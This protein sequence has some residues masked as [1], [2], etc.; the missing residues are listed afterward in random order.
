MPAAVLLV[1]QGVA[2][3]RIGLEVVDAGDR[4]RRGAERRMG[5]DV[6][7][8]LA[9]DIDHAAVAQRF[10]MLLARAQHWR[11]SLLRFPAA[12]PYHAGRHNTRAITA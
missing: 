3:G 5:G 12:K 7:D 9:A 8:P 11:R 4:L 1:G 10:Q 2:V 6:V